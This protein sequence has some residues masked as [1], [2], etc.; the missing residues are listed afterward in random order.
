MESYDKLYING[1]WRYGRGS[2]LLENHDPYTGQL[3]YS[4]HGASI[5]DLNDAF[6][7]AEA[8]QPGWA[9]LLP[10]EKQNYLTRLYDAIAFYKEDIFELLTHE[11]GSIRA[12]AEF[13]YHTCLEFVREAMSYPHMLEGRI[14]PST[15][16]GKDNYIFKEPKGVIAV[17]APWNVPL[18]LAMRS[19][20]PAIATGNT[21]VLKPAS[22]TPGSAFLIARIFERAGFPAGVFNAI[23]GKGSEIGDAMITH[24][25]PSLVSFTGS[26]EVGSRVGELAV[27]RFKDV[28]LELGG[29]NVMIVVDD[30]DIDHAA[31]AA[32]FG[33]FF[34]QGQVCM[35]IN[36]II[37]MAKVYERFVEAFVAKVKELPI[38]DPRDAQT[39]IGPMISASQVASVEKLIEETVAAGAVVALAGHTEG[40]I[41]TPW[42]FKDVTMEM[43]AAANEVFGPVCCV[44][45]SR[46]VDE[47]VDIANSSEHGLS[48]SIFTR[49]LYRGMMI[50]K[51]VKTGMIHI[52]DQTI[53][54]EP[55][56]MF[57]GEKAS[58][59]G[60]FNGKWVV[61][62]FTTDRWIS[63]QRQY[64]F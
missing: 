1:Q 31:A 32:A 17:I 44:I 57:G 24:P 62:K 19:V 53:N 54:D 58:G 25:T 60:R 61:D 49:D 40:N 4:Y 13:E 9:A 5:D 55:H 26:T 21:V 11:A 3:L 18:V 41:I 52:N 64:R 6:R 39:F 8:A 10:N 12:K 38:G 47:A 2:T 34:N 30:A 15:T 22:D 27:S 20:I 51:R 63:V 50:G 36:R 14:L 56:V 46:D 59:I 23:A 45:K 7:A 43:S 28:S 33:A 42:I 29:N 16:P 48:G 35:A 37:V